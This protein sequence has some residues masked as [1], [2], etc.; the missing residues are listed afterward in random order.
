MAYDEELG[1][2]MRTQDVAR[3][4]NI[5]SNTVR[6][7]NDRGIIKAYRI[8]R[9]GDRRYSREDIIHFLAELNANGGDERKVVLSQQ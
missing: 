8:N 6:R 9:R 2:S 7:W 3:L 4:L 1:Q 5:H